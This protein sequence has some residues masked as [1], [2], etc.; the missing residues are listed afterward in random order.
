MITLTIA[1]IG[2]LVRWRRSRK[3]KMDVKNGYCVGRKIF[4]GG[5]KGGVGVLIPR[6]SDTPF[7][8]GAFVLQALKNKPP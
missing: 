2:N 3:L 4:L 1:R 6:P 7:I 5:E 8:K